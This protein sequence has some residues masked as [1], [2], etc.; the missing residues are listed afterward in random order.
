MGDSVYRFMKYTAIMLAVAWGGYAVYESFFMGKDS[1][2]RAYEAGQRLFEDRLY[3]RALQKFDES[4]ESR[5]GTPYALRGRALALM[6]LGRNEEAL[7]TFAEAIEADPEQA[8]NYANR[9]ILFDRMGYHEEALADYEH[10]LA[11]DEIVAKGPHWLTRLLRNQPERPPTVADRARYLREQLALPE[12]E[13]IL[14]VPEVDEQQRPF[15]L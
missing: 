14:R 5:P 6:Q 3:E 2:T 1:S 4:L 10:A 9:G 8:V 13:R 11:L 12:S 7:E 15:K